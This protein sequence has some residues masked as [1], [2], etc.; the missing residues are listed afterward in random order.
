MNIYQKCG[1][2][3]CGQYINTARSDYVTLVDVSGATIFLHRRPCVQQYVEVNE[4][5]DMQVVLGHQKTR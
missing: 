3:N 4:Y 1:N 5:T 2:P